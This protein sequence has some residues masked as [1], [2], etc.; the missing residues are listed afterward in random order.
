MEQQGRYVNVRAADGK[1]LLSL[2]F[3][4]G[5]GISL[6]SKLDNGN[7]GQHDSRGNGGNCKSNGGTSSDGTGMTYPQRRLL[8][9]LVAKEGFERDAG[10]KELLRRFKV[11]SLAEIT[12]HDASQMIDQI[13]KETK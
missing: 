13:L 4:A 10:E 8:F 7:G 5:S 1:V 11:G 12:K 6:E 9:R 2:Y 3:D